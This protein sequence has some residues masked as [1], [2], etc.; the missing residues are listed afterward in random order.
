[1]IGTEL[2]CPKCATVAI[3]RDFCSCGE[4]LGWEL[5]TAAATT[6]A[7]EPPAYRAPAPAVP[8]AATLLTLR[9]PAREADDAGATVSVS[10]MPGAAVT[11]LAT[12]RNQGEI[13]DTYDV[14]VEGLPAGWTTIAPATVFLNPWGSS[15]EYQQELEIHLHPPRTSASVARAWPLTVVA[16][17]RSLN[18]DVAS[19]PA[20][21]TVEPFQH[22]VMRVGP[23]RRHGRRHGRFEVAVENHGNAPADVIIAARDSEARCP[24]S[25]APAR[26]TVPIGAT[27]GALVLVGVPR[28]LFFK[29]P[30]DH[31]V[32]V[33]H[34]VDGV[35]SAPQRVV[36]RQKPWLPWWLPVV[37]A[38]LAAFVAAVLLLRRDPEVPKL[39]G[40][41]VAEALVVLEK[42]DLKLGRTTTMTA[43][44]GVLPGTILD[45]QPAAGDDIVKGEAVHVTVAA[46]AEHAAVPQVHGL[47]LAAATAKLKAARF[48]H[49]PQPAAAGDDWVVI[50][51]HPTPGSTHQVG[52]PVT[53][54]VEK[55]A[56]LA[57][58]AA[59]ATA[60]PSATASATPAATATSV[61]SSAPKVKAPATPSV[62]ARVS[63]SSKASLP[64]DLV[65]A[66]AT[67]GQLY[68]WASKDA[69][70]TRL[71]AARYRFE[72]P[73]PTEAGFAAVHVDDGA[74]RLVNVS[75]DGKTVTPIAEGRFHRPDYAPTRGLLAA[76]SRDGKGGPA[77]AGRLCVTDP[78][79]PQ[80]PACAP[81]LSRG[82]RVGRPAWAP[83]GRSVL[84][85]GAPRTG[86]YDALL[87]YVAYGGDAAHWT[88]PKTVYRAAGIR[89][90]VWLDDDRVA[91]LVAARRGARP[92]LRILTRR[93][94]GQLE[95]TKDFPALTG[96]ELAASGHHVA[97]RRGS[98]AQDGPI[99]LLDVDRDRPRLRDLPSGVNPTWVD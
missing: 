36:L 62:S 19:V 22:T 83:D 77:D 42:R 25:V 3:N 68:R 90:A 20:T 73:T 26:A 43:P 1:M 28:P 47:T 33:T 45:Q 31:R 13:V 96:S 53:L 14:R 49:D 37:A 35:E 23:E 75:A 65:F 57:A 66:G 5:N 52:K 67:S 87:S 9:D 59:T 95:T 8:R 51:Q 54:A 21:L 63:T 99:T 79:E 92:H 50:R 82:R 10:V 74:R 71:T 41:T 81:A 12:V 32:E 6:R 7:T 48:A 85:L 24:V 91:A 76:I 60:T 39:K 70:A 15:G 86:G 84:V 16:R 94:G 38:L 55:R 64:G 44:E 78:A 34:R 27:A 29:H 88:T 58:P 98:D 18:E 17:S 61:P 72:T 97:L 56:A 30:I 69:K 93:A 2:E 40:D 80:A 89:A 11:V 4:Y 46:A